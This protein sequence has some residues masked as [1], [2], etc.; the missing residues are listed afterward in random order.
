MGALKETAQWV[1]TTYGDLGLFIGLFLEFIG[2]PFPGE[3]SQAFAG[4]LISQGHLNLY[5]TLPI[6]IAGSLFGSMAAHVIGSRYGHRLLYEWGPRLG[7]K[8]RYIEKSE[9]WFRKN[10]LSMILFSRWVLGVRHVTPYFTGLVRMPFWEA[11]FWNLIGSIL[12][13]VPLIFIGILV[14]EAYE[15]FMHE[16][17]RYVSLLVWGAVIFGG[18]FYLYYRTATRPKLREKEANAEENPKP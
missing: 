17:H 15:A 12:W 9:K 5:I 1:V 4:F 10:R 6:C 7:L 3:L 8:R 11:F 18:F 16:F 13:C 14:G 2:F